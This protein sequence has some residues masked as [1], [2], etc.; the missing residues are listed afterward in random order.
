MAVL[1]DGETDIRANDL[2]VADGQWHTVYVPFD[3]LRYF[4]PGLQNEPLRL[5]R[6]S[7]LGLGSKELANAMEVSDLILVGPGDK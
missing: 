6:I 4:T 7:T 3:Q 5:D 1:V 2:F